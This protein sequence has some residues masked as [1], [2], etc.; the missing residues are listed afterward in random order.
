MGES[1]SMWTPHH[2]WVTGWEQTHHQWMGECVA[3][4]PPTGDQIHH[5]Q[6][7]EWESS[8]AS[9]EIGTPSHS[10]PLTT[11]SPL[12]LARGSQGIGGGGGGGSNQS[13]ITES[14]ICGKTPI[15]YVLW[16]NKTTMPTHMCK[17]VDTFYHDQFVVQAWNFMLPQQIGFGPEFWHSLLRQ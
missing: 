7:I 1:R 16:P 4:S 11:S 2:R 3:K 6:C 15:I 17:L 5:L 13:W 9:P 8:V 14:K 12:A 10:F